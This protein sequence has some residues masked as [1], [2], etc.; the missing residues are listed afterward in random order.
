ME[1]KKSNI[2]NKVKKAYKDSLSIYDEILRSRTWWSKLYLKIFWGGVNDEFIAHE[3]L[4]RIPKDFKGA[5]LDIPVGTG[6][7]TAK[8]YKGLKNASIKGVDYSPE[9]LEKCKILMEK[10]EVS[11]DLR[12]GDV[13]NLQFQDETFDMLISMNGFH[14]FPNKERAYENC[15]RVL[16]KDGIFLSC[17]YIKEEIKSA[18]ILV[19]NLLAPKGWFTPPFDNRKSLLEKLNEDFEIQWFKVSGSIA[20]FQCKKK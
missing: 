2:N 11:I 18:D 5:I 10:E 6:I 12:R 4:M 7:F 1:S 19:N 16:K 15:L 8:Y 14:A 17:F 13:G 20:S 3:L 9:M